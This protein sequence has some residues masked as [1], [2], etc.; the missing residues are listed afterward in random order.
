MKSPAILFS[1]LLL[2]LFFTA[3]E[4]D[5]NSKNDSDITD[6]E[7]SP[8]DDSSENGQPDIQELFSNPDKFDGK[9][10]TVC[11]TLVFYSFA[12]EL[13]GCLELSNDCC[14]GA[15]WLIG[16][17]GENDDEPE[18]WGEMLFL[19]DK[20]IRGSECLPD[21]T[22]EFKISDFGRKLCVTGTFHKELGKYGDYAALSPYIAIDE[23]EFQ[24]EE[25]VLDDG[26]EVVN[27]LVLIEGG[28]FLQGSKKETVNLGDFYIQKYEVTVRDY[29]KCIDSGTCNNSAETRMYDTYEN[30]FGCNIGSENDADNP[31]NCISLEGAKT[32][33]EW[34]G[35]RLPTELEREKAARGTDGRKYPWGEKTPDCNIIIMN[36]INIMNES[37]AGCGTFSTSVVGSKPDGA[38]PYGIMDMS[39]NVSEWIESGIALGGA[40]CDGEYGA[41]EYNSFRFYTYNYMGIP[42][43]IPELDNSSGFRCAKAS[44]T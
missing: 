25:P 40:F 27:E 23:F 30:F 31:A 10:V 43:N 17:K 22:G 12:Q 42:V 5:T 15:D 36:N 28:D 9:K 38:S 6:S 44:V 18:P 29:Q 33:C 34:K 19:V 16:F 37:I 14:N 32:Y 4:N 7:D 39:G 41:G 2:M 20:A 24:D 1:V 13:M 8:D 11:D 3:C 21:E 35:M 26:I